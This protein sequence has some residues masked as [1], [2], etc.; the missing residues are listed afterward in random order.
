MGRQSIKTQVLSEA[1]PIVGWGLRA[2][3]A[4]GSVDDILAGF[5]VL[6]R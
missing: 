5:A 4:L 1:V 3:L 6:A 2:A